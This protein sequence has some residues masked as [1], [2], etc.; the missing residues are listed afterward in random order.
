MGVVKCQTIIGLIEEF[1]PK[2]LAE[3]WDNVGLL[4]GDGSQPVS[5]LMVSLDVP[6]WVVDEAIENKVD[7]IVC[8]HPIIFSGLK[9]VNSDT[10]LGRKL[11][12]LIK[13]NISVYC[14]HTNYDFA[15]GGLND[16]FAWQLGLKDFDTIEAIHTE[17]LYKIAVYVPKEHV[18][19]VMDAMTAAGAG[20]IGKYSS[21]TFRS[22]GLGTFKGEEGSK[23][24]IGKV[25]K[26]ETVEEY[27][28][29]TIASER[30]LN[31]VIAK[32]QKAHPYEEVAYDVYLLQNQGNV[33]GLGRIGE[34]SKEM[35]LS[36]YAAEVKELLGLN[37][38][39]LAGDLDKKIKKV[40][41]QNGCGNKFAANARFAGADV[42]VTG[43]MQYHEISDALEAGLCII[44]AGHFA[45]EK[46]MIKSMAEYLNNRFI[47]LK[48]KI[49]VLESKSNTDPIKTI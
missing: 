29:E 49:E 11:L 2:K 28:L 39:R 23:P 18:E 30:I 10:V 1:A 7:L 14:T 41:V 45:T 44:D 43:D 21:C 22:E 4:V 24:Y 20:Y 35:T 32:M 15:K 31:K 9:R 37:E 48:Y 46:I 42:L 34:L 27:K 19:K 25:E 8:H 12:K 5:K 38:I 17:K 13:N 36:E 6:E 40:A 3:S 33:L 47:D 16:I 26:L